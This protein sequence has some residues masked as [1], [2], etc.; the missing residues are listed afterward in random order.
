MDGNVGHSVFHFGPLPSHKCVSSSVFS[1]L[2]MSAVDSI[3]EGPGDRLH[4]SGSV[5][6]AAPQT[7]VGALIGIKVEFL[8]IS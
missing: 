3:S 1:W 8:K 2:S 5:A 4:P 6:V 7:V